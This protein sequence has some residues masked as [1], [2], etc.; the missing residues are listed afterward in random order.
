VSGIHERGIN[1]GHKRDDY[2][3]TVERRMKCGGWANQYLVGSASLQTLL[4]QRGCSGE[5]LTTKQDSHWPS[6]TVGSGN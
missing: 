6:F 1:A 5:S 3:D 2:I 4:Q